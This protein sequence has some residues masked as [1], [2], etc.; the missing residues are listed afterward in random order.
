[1]KENEEINRK[2]IAKF[3]VFGCF[4]EKYTCCLC[5]CECYT[6]E[7][8]SNSGDRLICHECYHNK[9]K[10]FKDARNWINRKE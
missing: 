5:G 2:N 1:M 10:T 9:F 3:Y 4:S 8:F 7:S 6:D